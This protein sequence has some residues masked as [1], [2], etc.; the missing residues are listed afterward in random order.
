M[1]RL[2]EDMVRR[3][4]LQTRKNIFTRK[5]TLL[6]IDLQYSR[7]QKCENE[8]LWFTPSSPV[9]LVWQ[10]KLTHP[11]SPLCEQEQPQEALRDTGIQLCSSSSCFSNSLMRKENSDF[12]FS[13]CVLNMNVSLRMT[14]LAHFAFSLECNWT[15][16]LRALMKWA[17]YPVLTKWALAQVGQ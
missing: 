1:E 9:F 10:R 6:D 3:W 13:F 12:I 17:D 5:Q 15:C 11:P 7:H 2:C 8:I 14:F 16:K 4:H